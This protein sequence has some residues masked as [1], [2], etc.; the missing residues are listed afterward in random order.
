MSENPRDFWTNERLAELRGHA[1]ERLP[2]TAIAAIFGVT[3]LSILTLCG[4]H[5][6]DIV[7]HTDAEEAGRRACAR[8]RESR[9]RQ[10]HAAKASK[11]ITVSVQLGTSK[12]APV[13]RN[14]LPR[15]PEMSKN[16][17]REMLAQAARNTAGM[18]P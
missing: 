9:K 17:L 3:K 14:Q 7:K 5:Q 15:I 1:A 4:K 12:T 8:L 11:A 6:I 18:L 10:K 2:A 13:Y 16:A